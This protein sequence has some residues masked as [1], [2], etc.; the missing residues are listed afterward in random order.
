[1]TSG[2]KVGFFADGSDNSAT[3]PCGR[4]ETVHA[5]VN[6]WFRWQV[7]PLSGSD[8]VLSS[9]TSVPGCAVS[10]SGLAVVVGAAAPQLGML[11]LF[12]LAAL[13]RLVES[14]TTRRTP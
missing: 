14:V 4:P 6:V 13:D 1:M 5:Y 9:C 12:S 8:A 2:V 3:E 10:V 7:P 11:T